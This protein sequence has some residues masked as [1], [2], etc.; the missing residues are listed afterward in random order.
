MASTEEDCIVIGAGI[1]GVS[2]AIHLLR[3]GRRVTLVDRRGPGEETSYG[4]AGVVEREGLVPITFPSS[5]AALVAFALNRTTEA[6]Y[7]ASA[8]PA[9]WPWL[10]A[11]RRF[12]RPDAVE[13]YAAASNA[14]EA[15]AWEDHRML[16]EAAGAAGLFRETGWLRLYRTAAGFREAERGLLPKAAAYGAS[17]VPLSPEEVVAELEPHLSPVF[18]RAILCA[19]TR[20]V[21]SPGDVTKAYARHFAASGGVILVAE[22][23]SIAPVDGAG[24]TVALRDGSVRR[25]RDVVVAAG[26]WAGDLLAPLGYRFPLAV[27]RGY[28]RHYRP[29]GNAALARPVV[30]MEEGF[31]IT[32]MK[33]GIRL[34]TGI[35]FA[36][37]DAPPTPVQVGRAVAKARDLFPLGEGVE[38]KPW[39]GARPCFPDSLPMIGPAPRHAGLW[40]AIGHGHLG[41][42]EGP[43]TGRL[44]A[45]MM[46]GEPTP[47][48]MAP[49]RTDRFAT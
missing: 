2:S 48:D 22:V 16:A 28:H 12:S 10:M 39:M 21:S 17:A 25:A 49:Y 11:L 40:L 30:D 42:T 43:V 38:P 41:F 45:T 9:V 44:L 47:I 31:V 15:L 8:L 32:P 24:W 27:K 6:H 33:D 4:N 29:K 18:H 5:L 36:R 13:R 20:S 1:V 7:H 23:A 46:A 34:T 3:R 14:L 19:D 37:R 35:E 26:P